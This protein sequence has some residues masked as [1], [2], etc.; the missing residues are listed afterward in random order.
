L[1]QH[2]RH[3]QYFCQEHYRQIRL[4]ISIQFGLAVWFSSGQ[5]QQTEQNRTN[6]NVLQISSI[7]DFKVQHDLRIYSDSRGIRMPYAD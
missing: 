4:T 5:E 2:W 3:N 1:T 6:M 7:Q